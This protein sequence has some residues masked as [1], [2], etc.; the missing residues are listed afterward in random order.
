MP[1]QIR[2][3]TK[4]ELELLP[5]PLAEGELVYVTDEEKLY[6]GSGA[7][8]I[9][10][11]GYGNEQ[12]QD[13]AAALF[14]NG[15]HDVIT[16]TYNDVDNKIDTSVDLTGYADNISFNEVTTNVVPSADNTYNLGS[17][18]K[19]WDNLYLGGVLQLGGAT[20]TYTGSYVN[21]PAGSTI[22][23]QNIEQIIDSINGNLRINVIGADSS[24]IVNSETNTVNATVVG[25]LT[26]SVF[27]ESSTVIIDATD[28]SVHTSKL[29]SDSTILT[30]GSVTSK[31]NLE[32]YPDET[33]SIGSIKINARL[34]GSPGLAQLGP[35][36]RFSSVQNTVA[37]P[38]PL[39]LGDN[40][41]SFQFGGYI[42]G[43]TNGEISADLAAIKG[44]IQ[45][46]GDTISNYARAK[47]QLFVANGDNP[48]D[49][50]TAEFTNKGVLSAPIL[51]TGTYADATARDAAIPTPE[52]GMI[53]FLT[54]TGKFQGNTNGTT[55]GWSDLN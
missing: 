18:L 21:L 1:L 34:V 10:V 37:S 32:L 16:F 30:V 55:G 39:N 12:A 7:A 36:I 6:I 22:G 28:N 51:K 29:L 38:T 44:I 41:G 50:V 20:V 19:K 27:G 42:N 24:I 43:G 15:T 4:T 26:G 46:A 14:D 25:D 53:I 48:A 52:V 9:A 49:A 31:T 3:G 54:S 11:T 47:I 2:R 23:G 45:D 35:I 5:N 8:N 13:A 40:L 17:T 33:Q